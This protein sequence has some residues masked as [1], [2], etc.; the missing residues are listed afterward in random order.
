M[1]KC[2][3][4]GKL[5]RQ[6]LAERTRETSTVRKYKLLWLLLALVLL[7]TGALAWLPKSRFDSIIIH[8]SA[9]QVDN[10]KSIQ[11]YHRTRGMGEAA[12]HLLLSNGST[13]VPLGN[14]EATHRY[15]TLSHALGTR[16]VRHNLTGLHVCV[17]GN[18]ETGS[19]SENMKPAIAH[20]IKGLQKKFGIPDNKILFHRD[21]GQTKCPGRYFSK[22]NLQKWLNNL[23]DDCLPSIAIQQNQVIASAGFSLAT[24]PVR[25]VVVIMAILLLFSLAWISARHLVIVRKEARATRSPGGKTCH[26]LLVGLDTTRFSL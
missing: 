7:V 17:V 14:L 4:I 8:H 6:L 10:Y 16:S 26:P 1:D 12:Y 13:R 11:R 2:L 5:H 22:G 18:Y 23:A 19:V 9:S 3:T 21:V 15:T 20:A 25:A 24:A